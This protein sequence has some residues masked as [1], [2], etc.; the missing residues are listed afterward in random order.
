MFFGPHQIVRNP[1]IY[2]CSH[3]PYWPVPSSPYRLMWE[4]WEAVDVRLADPRNFRRNR[5][6]WEILRKTQNLTFLEAGK[7]RMHA[8]VPK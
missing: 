2:H 7:F 1:R 5:Q 6:L 4:I 8:K 3:C